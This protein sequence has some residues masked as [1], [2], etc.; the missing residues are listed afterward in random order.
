MSEDFQEMFEEETREQIE[1]M[2]ENLL[3]LEEDPTDLE[4]IEEV[5]RA[6]HTLKGMAGTMGY[7]GIQKISHRM[8]ELFDDLKSEGDKVD[9]RLFE[10]LFECVDTIEV[11][12]T[13]EEEDYEYLIDELEDVI[14]DDEG[15]T[16]IDK[17]GTQLIKNADLP[18]KVKETLQSLSEKEIT[19]GM[20]EISE[21]ERLPA[22][23]GIE[24]REKLDFE[25]EVFCP[26]PEE[27]DSD[28]D[29]FFVVTEEGLDKEDLDRTTGLIIDIKRDKGK[30]LLEEKKDETKKRKI[31]TS[32]KLKVDLEDIEH[33]MNLIS[34]LV[35][36]KGS[37]E[38][39]SNSLDSDRLSSVTK[40]IDR[41]SGELRETVLDL[42]MTEVRSVFRRFPRM[43]RDI[44]KEK[45][46]K[47][48]FEM[49]GENIEL[50]RT[51]LERITDPLVHLLR[52]AVDHGIEPVEERKDKGKPPEGKIKLTATQKEENVV[53]EVSDDGR[54][55][56]EEKIKEKALEKGL[57]D[58]EE[59]EDIPEEDLYMF[60]FNSHFSTT[61]GV[62]EVSGRGV[63]MDVVKETM[64]SLGGDVIIKSE[65]DEGTTIKLTL[66]PSV[67][68]V[69]AFLVRV[70]DGTYAISLEDIVET[71]QV[72]IEDIE[73]IKGNDFIRLRDEYIP[74]IYIKEEFEEDSSDP[75][76]NEKEKLTVTI[77]STE[78]ETAGFVIDEVITEKEIVIK[79]LPENLQSMGGFRGATILGDGTIAMIL[80]TLYW[81]ETTS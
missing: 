54:G 73:K 45:D 19:L 40:R 24:L 70:G 51:I 47:V 14:S 78:G 72:K 41:I 53:I 46:K 77:V 28:H 49:E 20:I 15:E 3:S 67:A 33:V 13:G 17:T 74:L 80:D 36:S 61:D 4:L 37:L 35:I 60:V 2:N 27:V 34:E 66:P 29:E 43:V 81:I 25:C 71:T 39:L 56:D 58:E 6:S 59:I 21:D 42:K 50:D 32:D 9:E 10:L 65:K 16:K 8:E 68:I 44:A 23:R 30:K 52:N 69:Q 31:A 1:K 79:P 7:E 11:L 5:Y 55:L 62:T 76:K 63:G 64:D 22:V 57:I 75:I 12:A 26:D 48:D 18:E 38:D